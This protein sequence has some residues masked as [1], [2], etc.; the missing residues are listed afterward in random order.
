LS[1][2]G[3]RPEDFANAVDVWPD[4]LQAANVFI[5]MATQWRVGFG[6]AVGL[7]Y[8]VLPSVFR[9]VGVPRAQW[10]DTFECIRVMEG[11]ALKVMGEQSND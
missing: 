6:G 10:S 4:N 11:E 9:L 1:A 2:L 3:F 5:A 7:D 8:N